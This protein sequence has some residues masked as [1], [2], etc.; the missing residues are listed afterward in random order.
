M[1]TFMAQNR[2]ERGRFDP[3]SLQM[4]D[5]EVA[6]KVMPRHPRYYFESVI[7]KTVFDTNGL[8]RIELHPID[9]GFDAPI[10]DIGIPSPAAGAVADRILQRLVERCAAFGTAVQVTDGTGIINGQHD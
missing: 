5:N 4:S 8:R 2:P 10:A 9:L 3:Y 7:T 1:E 6:A